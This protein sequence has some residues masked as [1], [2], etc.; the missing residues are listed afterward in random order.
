MNEFFVFEFHSFLPLFTAKTY[1]DAV[2]TCTAQI[3]GRAFSGESVCMNV[4]GLCPYF[5]IQIEGAV[6]EDSIFGGED[7]LKAAGLHS[8]QFSLSKVEKIAFYQFQVRYNIFFKVSCC[9]EG[10][11]KRLIDYAKVNSDLNLKIFEVIVCNFSVLLKLNSLIGTYFLHATV[12]VGLWHSWYG[13]CHLKK[14]FS[15]SS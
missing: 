1:N 6:S 14:L 9:N 10:I 15:H 5:Y 4:I 8:G 11:R 3:F 12:Y 13:E 7:R 2:S